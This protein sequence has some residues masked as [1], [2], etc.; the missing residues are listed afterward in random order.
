[1]YLYLSVTFWNFTIGWSGGSHLGS[2]F[3]VALV[4]RSWLW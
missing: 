1:M 3:L 4:A 2:G